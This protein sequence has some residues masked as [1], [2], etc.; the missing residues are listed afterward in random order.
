LLDFFQDWQPRFQAAAYTDSRLE[1]ELLA[2]AALAQNRAWVLSHQS[3]TLTAEQGAQLQNWAER[4]LAGEP[5]AYLR[6]WQEFFGHRFLVNQHTLIPRPETELLVEQLLA[7][8]RN[9]DGDIIDLGCGSGCIVISAALSLGQRHHYYGL[10]ISDSALAVAA[11][12]AQ[13]LGAEVDFHH[14]DLL[15]WLASPDYSTISRTP[16]LIAANLPYVPVAALEQAP[17]PDTIGLRYEPRQALVSGPD[18]LDHYRRLAQQLTQL[19]EAQPQ[20]QGQLLMEIQPGQAETMFSLF[21][22]QRCQLQ[23]DYAGKERL[24]ICRF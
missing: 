14:S 24:I 5:L 1:L 12:N 16:L 11:H 4:R 22:R 6:G 10:D 9:H 7:A 21:G 3:D 18:G 2:A 8:A 20:L 17:Q 13:I 19:T 23:H 15:S